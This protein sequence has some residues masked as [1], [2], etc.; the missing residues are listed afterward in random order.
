MSRS[1]SR[2]LLAILLISGSGAAVNELEEKVSIDGQSLSSEELK[3]ALGECSEHSGELKP[4]ECLDRFFVPRWLMDREARAK[5]L[6]VSD[7]F[8]HRKN[9]IIHRYFSA[10]LGEQ[11]PPVSEDEAK[12]FLKN[13]RDFHKPLR[14]R[15]F[16]I[17]VASEAEAKAVLKELGTNVNIE[18]FRKA[19]RAHSLDTATNERGGDLGFVW[20][21]GSTDVPQ[22]KAEVPL[23]EAGLTLIDGQLSQ[24]PIAEGK[25]FAILWRRGSLPAL[26]PDERAEQIARLRIREKKTEATLQKL[27]HALKEKHVEKRRNILLGKLRRTNATLF[28]EKL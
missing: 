27:L 5:K 28:R 22:V 10:H 1:H 14:L 18:Q 25:R 20:P 7:T 21:D 23:Y 6:D 24:A 12:Q 4:H 9:D 26:K 11:L 2:L 8:S 13:S 16:R 15:L 3:S 17:L 19:A